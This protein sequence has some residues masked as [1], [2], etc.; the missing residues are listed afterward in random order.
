MKIRIIIITI[1]HSQS[2]DQSEHTN[3]ITE[4]VLQYVLEKASNADFT[5]FL[6]IFKQIFNNSINTFTDQTF[7]EIIY[8]FNLTN[9]FDVISDSDVREFKIKY[10]IHQQ[11]AQN[12]I[13]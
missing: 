7:N 2:D 5:D 11:E 9:F 10:K 12:S 3:Q 4:I 8:E 1:Y 13:A 6:L